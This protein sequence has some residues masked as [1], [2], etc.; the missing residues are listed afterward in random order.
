MI[1]PVE[2]STEASTYFQLPSSTRMQQEKAGL[3]GSNGLSI[4]PLPDMPLAAR[5]EIMHSG[6]IAHFVIKARLISLIRNYYHGHLRRG[7]SS[8]RSMAMTKPLSPASVDR[9]V[10]VT[11]VSM[12][13]LQRHDE[14]LNFRQLW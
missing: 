13:V 9:S 5:D 3:V 12:S 6:K 11:F 1:A 4:K 14:L 10:V 7:K 2:K 8:H